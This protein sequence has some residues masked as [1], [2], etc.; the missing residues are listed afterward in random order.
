MEEQLNKY[1]SEYEKLLKSKD[2][3]MLSDSERGIVSRFSTEKE[4]N[5]TRKIILLNSEIIKEDKKYVNP[6][7]E[8][9]NN[10]IGAI[11]SK[12][13]SFD[14]FKVIRNILE[15]RVRVYQFGIYAVASI[16]LLIFISNR[17][18]IVTVQNPVYISKTDTA[19]KYMANDSDSNLQNPEQI[20]YSRN[21]NQET[22]DKEK[23]Q[24]DSRIS[25]NANDIELFGIPVSTIDNIRNYKPKVRSLFDDS[26]IVKCFAKI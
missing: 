10:L 7:P 4:Y 15:Y 26:S 2:Y 5:E 13:T 20:N 12:N 8:I 16:I 18:K 23:P 6:D 22:L 14:I 19:E 25:I 3:N 1:F 21:D 11:K 24:D 9:L 17:G